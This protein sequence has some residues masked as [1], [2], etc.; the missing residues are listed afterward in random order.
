MKL[1]FLALAAVAVIAG[2]T[3]N[4]EVLPPTEVAAVSYRNTGP[5][6]L[7]LY[8]IVNRRTGAGAHTALGVN[9]SEK[10]LF[11]PAGGFKAEGLPRSG[12]VLYGFSPAFEAAYSS[13]HARTQYKVIKTT[14][15][16][17]PEVASLALQKVKANGSVASAHCA[18]STSAI[19][20]TLP[21]FETIEQTYYPTV[22]EAQYDRLPGAKIETI[23]EDD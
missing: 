10:V 20:Q 2:C 9:A 19:L 7:T 3:R 1:L 17:S 21:G 14:I 11:D 13:A 5:T 8:T 12:D 15:P 18:K 16:V 22:L 23:I 6:S 4:P